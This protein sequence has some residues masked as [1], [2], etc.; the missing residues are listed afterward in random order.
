MCVCQALQVTVLA[1][2]QLCNKLTVHSFINVKQGAVSLTCQV[3]N[4]L[5]GLTDAI[6]SDRFE[7]MRHVYFFILHC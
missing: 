2:S 3:D 6:F 5:V 1:F 7:E 4:S